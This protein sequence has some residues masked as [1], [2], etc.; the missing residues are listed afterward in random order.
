MNSFM[1]KSISKSKEIIPKE[2][3]ITFTVIVPNLT[4]LSD[5][6]LKQLRNLTIA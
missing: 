3:E 5:K 1:L 2:A 6:N 4:T